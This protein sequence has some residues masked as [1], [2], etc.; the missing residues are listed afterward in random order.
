M[1]I[2][3]LLFFYLFL[4]QSLAFGQTL[5]SGKVLDEK[6]QALP[7][8]NVFI[9]GSFDGA[10]TNAQGEFQFE[11][12]E[13]GIQLLV[14]SMM[15]F[16]SLEQVVTLESSTLEIQPIVLAEE[17][18]ELNTVT[19]S[20]GAMEASDEKKSV[21]LRPLDIVTTPSAMG[22]IMGAFQTL[23]GTSTVGNDGRLFVRGGDASEVGIYIDG[24]RVG[25]AY[26]TTAGNVPTRTRFNPNLFK[27]TFFSTGGYSAEYG[28]A[29]S[30]ALAL[31]TKDL[32]RRSQGD[33]SIMSIGGG[34]SHTLAN[35]NQSLTASANYFNLAPYQQLI[36][37]EIDFDL[38]P[39]GWDLELAAQKKTGKNGLLKVMARTESGGMNL[40]SPLPGTDRRVMVSLINDYSYAQANWRTTLNKGWSIFTGASISKNLDKLGFDSLQIERRND[41]AHFKAS[42]IKDFSDRFSAKFGVEHFLHPYSEKLVKQGWVR[43]FKDQE[44]YLFTEWDYYFTKA[45]VLRGGLR[46][47]TSSVAEEQWVDPRISLAYQLPKQGQISLAAGRFHQLPMDNF[48]VLNTNLQNSESKHL[49]LNYLLSKEGITFRAE[50][51]YKSYDNLVTFE[52]S[53]ENPVSLKNQGEGFAKG[54]DFFFR[55]RQ[56]FK[57]TDYW[58]T[59]SF[60]DSKRQFNQYQTQVQPSFA[61]KHNLSVVVKHF[62]VPL[63]SQLGASF[64]FNDGY[65][66]TDPNLDN[67]EMSSKTKSFQNLSLSWSYLPKPNL[68]IHLACTNVLGR[69]NVFGYSFS[70]K[71]NTEGIFESIPQGQVAPRFLFLGIFLTLSKDKNAN[72]LNNL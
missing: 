5:I 23:P 42:A 15:G 30:S 45:F 40:W 10:S 49:L 56:T 38:A 36:K 24:L 19:I 12:S 53:L 72:Q 52:G 17:F 16:K 60:V 31:N 1:N 4:A 63:K 66:Y 41:L 68:I 61:P 59:Y 44:T 43:D 27:G 35:E 29:L 58:V 37:Q 2:R 65:T 33:L 11:T 50:A 32:S 34:Y 57:N 7:G 51:F 48:R 28:Q 13:E 62:I 3:L 20:A 39:Y 26:G 54:L 46:A 64:A 47:G 67:S 18:N 55:D 22:D 21:I 9:K 69:D 70:P 14:F 6:N 71:A 25:N 8:V